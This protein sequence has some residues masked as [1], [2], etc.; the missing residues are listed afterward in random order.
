MANTENNNKT[1]EGFVLS[2]DANLIAYVV[3]VIGALLIIIVKSELKDVAWGI[4]GTGIV[5]FIIEWIKRYRVSKQMQD[6]LKEIQGIL[7]NSKGYCK[8]MRTLLRQQ[9]CLGINFHTVKPINMDIFQQEY[10]KE[11]KIKSIFVSGGTMSTVL[12]EE[13]YSIVGQCSRKC[14]VILAFPNI[15]NPFI[16]SCFLKFFA[17]DETQVRNNIGPLLTAI[18]YFKD[19]SVQISLKCMNIF[20]PVAYTA[21]DYDE[22][23]SDNSIIYAKYYKLD[24]EEGEAEDF[25]IS[26]KPCSDLYYIYAQKIKDI[27]SNSDD[28]CGQFSQIAAETLTR[29]PK[30]V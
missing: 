26:V 17:R 6:S 14:K 12:G 15:S 9:Q 23:S 30:Q 27:T 20:Q 28:Y 13:N 7:S 22:M 25:W 4:F 3:I 21:I 18:S 8:E 11:K 10:I 1:K 29:E 19:N 5:S 16:S 2:T 24:K